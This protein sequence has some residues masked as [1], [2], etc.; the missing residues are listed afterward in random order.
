MRSPSID[1]QERL[2][3]DR[4]SR[5]G[6]IYLFPY[7]EYPDLRSTNLS[8]PD[9]VGYQILD[10]LEVILEDVLHLERKADEEDSNQADFIKGL[11]SSPEV[12]RFVCCWFCCTQGLWKEPGSCSN[13]WYKSHDGEE[14]VP[15]VR[16]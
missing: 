10:F 16:S 3:Q 8:R 6:S 14:V 13:S 4:S 7:L 15:S 12:S 9:L 5:S 1:L 2:Q 11:R